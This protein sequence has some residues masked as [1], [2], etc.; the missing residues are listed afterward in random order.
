MRKFRVDTPAG[1]YWSVVDDNYERVEDA[2]EFLRYLRF[3]QD[4][5]ESTT[6]AYAGE[7]VSSWL[8]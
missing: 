3:G 1:S 6:E 8:G 4:R 7:L 2:D 5:A